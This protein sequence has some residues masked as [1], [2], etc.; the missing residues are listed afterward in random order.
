LLLWYHEVLF[1]EKPFPTCCGTRA[2]ASDY[3]SDNRLPYRHGSF[4]TI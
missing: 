1:E 2:V 4:T 3:P